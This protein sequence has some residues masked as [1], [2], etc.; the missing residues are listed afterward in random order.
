MKP[1]TCPA[2][3]SDKVVKNGIK[4]DGKQNHLCKDCRKQF[5]VR[6]VKPKE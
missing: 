1:L 5:I 6:D 4:P 3:G 2:C